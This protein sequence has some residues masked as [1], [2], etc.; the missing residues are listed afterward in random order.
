[1]YFKI[2]CPYCRGA[3]ETF[4]NLDVSYEK[5][6]VEQLSADKWTAV[7]KSTGSKTVP[8]IFVNEKFIGGYDDITARIKKE[9]IG[10]LQ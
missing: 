2:T 1:M 10:W 7:C 4:D 3:I 9:G 8:Q 5:I 6:D